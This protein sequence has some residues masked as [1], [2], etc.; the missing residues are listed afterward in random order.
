M[1]LTDTETVYAVAQ[2]LA[3][4]GVGAWRPNGPG[5]T[6]GEVGIFYGQI[7]TTPDRAIGVTRYTRL[8]FV[9]GDRHPVRVPYLQVRVRGATAP[10]SADDLAD[11]VDGVLQGLTRVGGLNY[12]ERVSG[13]APL[14][15]DG[16]GR[17]ELTINY[18]VSLEG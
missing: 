15:P 18:R 14:G 7:G 9:P 6:A 3:D 12:V 4:A 1:T 10:N 5:F 16:N 13:P 8:D 11:A 17:Q 2:V